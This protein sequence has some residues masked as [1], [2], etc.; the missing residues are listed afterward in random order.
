M[1][2]ETPPGEE[3]LPHKNPEFIRWIML[4][5]FIWGAALALGAF[6]FRHQYD[7]RKPLLVL[8]C[9][10]AFIFAWVVLLRKRFPTQLQ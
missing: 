2:I 1:S 10:T 5:L 7:V 8:G 6:L 4:G 3:T 9:V